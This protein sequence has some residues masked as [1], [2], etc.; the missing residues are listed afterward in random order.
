L[1]QRDGSVTNHGV[2]RRQ[3]L[4][5]VA[6]GGALLALPGGSASALGPAQKVR[7][8]RIRYDG[9][10]S[11]NSGAEVAMSEEIRLRTSIDMRDDPIVTSLTGPRM[12]DSLFAVMAGNGPFRL[13]DDER[14]ALRRWLGLGG[15]LLVDN[16]GQTD[17]AQGFDSS[18]RRELG[19]L[20]PHERITRVSPEHV[21]YRT[22]YRLD[23]PAGRAIHRPYLE[24]IR[25][26]RRY[27][28]L[29]NPN[30]LTGALVRDPGGRYVH[31]PSPGGETQREMAFRFGV[32]L[33]MYATCLHY[34]DDQVHLDHLLHSRKWRIRPPE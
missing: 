17:V 9:E 10:W 26:D 18:A 5:R 16:A 22:F 27:A 12:Y 31:V 2:N 7:I 23:Y 19:A 28:V 6:A 4:T 3:F 13:S 1:S 8:L 25:M 30:D 24:G 15:L 29:L 32:N 11:V 21:I 14:R 33:M 34:K 20:F